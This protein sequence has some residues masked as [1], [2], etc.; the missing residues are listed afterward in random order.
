M[1]NWLD[2]VLPPPKGSGKSA[3]L[4][5]VERK[6]PVAE[7][8]RPLPPEASRIPNA[9][10]IYGIGA[11]IMMVMS[12]FFLLQGQWFTALVILFPAICLFGYAMYF[13]RYTNR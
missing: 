3:Q 5:V 6:R 1:A 13:V 7:Y 4:P 2:K 11:T 10:L 8:G 12:L 9:S